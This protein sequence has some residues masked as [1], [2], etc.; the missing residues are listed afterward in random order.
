MTEWNDAGDGW[1]DSDESDEYDGCL[2]EAADEA[3]TVVCSGCGADVYEDAPMCPHCG[4][5]ITESTSAWSGRPGWWSAAGFLG[6]I[7]VI[8]ALL[9]LAN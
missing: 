3:A 9:L 7:A 5:F 4:E 6:I 2:D 8:L 1:D